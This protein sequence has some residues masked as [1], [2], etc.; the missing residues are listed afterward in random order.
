NIKSKGTR[1]NV[2]SALEKIISELRL[3]KKTPEHG[4]AIFCGNIS[5][6]PGKDE[7][8]LE[9][10]IPP[11]PLSAN[12]YRCSQKFVLDPLKE[13][14]ETG[15]VYGL[16]V[17]DRQEAD[18]AVLRGKSTELLVKL[19]SIVPGKFRA[20]GQ[21]AQRFERVAEGLLH[22]FF[23]EVAE[24][25]NTEFLK[26]QRLKGIIVGGPGPTKQDFLSAN[27]LHHEL[28]KKIL[29][30][31]DIGYTGESGIEELVNKSQGLLK[32]TAITKE[33]QLVSKFLEQLGKGTGLALNDLER[34][35]KAFEIGAVDIVLVSEKIRDENLINELKKLTEQTGASFEFIS[36]ETMEGQQ[37]A[38][39]GGIAAI[40]RFKI[41]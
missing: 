20:G 12:L 10:I 4:L 35:R 1:K 34:I 24:K 31:V 18:I 28:A 21:S 15:E 32:E 41:Q 11:K 16:I 5:Q 14:L 7:F 6:I 25:A 33:K 27:L 8:L 37:L 39:L 9:T 26:I 3:F 13:M 40:L 19:D 2:T 23:K 30:Q 36:Q 29:G 22:D 38:H 17:I